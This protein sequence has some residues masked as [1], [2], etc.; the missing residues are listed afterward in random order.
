MPE[1]KIHEIRRYAGEDIYLQQLKRITQG[2][3]PADQSSLPLLVTPYFSVRDELAVTDGL[4]FRL[5][6]RVIPLGMRAAVKKR[7]SL[8]FMNYRVVV[9]LQS[10]RVL[11]ILSFCYPA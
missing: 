10:W 1:E 5:E 8:V 11:F 6:R 9:E 7:A 2:G 4:I 3:W